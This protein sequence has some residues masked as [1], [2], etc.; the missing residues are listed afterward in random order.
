MRARLV[1]AI[2]ALGFA[3]AGCK[4]LPPSKPQ[5]ELTPTELQGQRV[6]NAYCAQCHYPTT[7]RPLHGPGLQAILKEQWLPS[8][9]PADDD[10]IRA[11]VMHG[12]NNMPAFNRQLSGSPQADQQMADLLAYLH[13]L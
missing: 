11:V 10:H 1:F 2:I 7:T 8:G 3:A 4:R 9:A 13:T 6:F 12:R 5:A